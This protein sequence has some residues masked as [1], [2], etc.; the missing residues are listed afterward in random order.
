GTF[1][2]APASGFQ[3]DGV[4]WTVQYNGNSIILDAVSL[5]GGLV[6]ATWNT[7]TG[8]WTTATQWNCTPG[9]GNCVPNN[10]ISNTYDAVLNSTGVG[11]TLT[12]DNSLGPITIDGLTLSAGT[13]K[14][15]SGASLNVLNNGI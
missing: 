1:A 6:T 8:N 5:V 2:N 14:I 3:M 13:L 9:P 15:L 4:N 11:D 10:S 12:L 7:G